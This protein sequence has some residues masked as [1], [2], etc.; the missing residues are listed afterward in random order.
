[1]VRAKAYSNRTDLNTALPKQAAS[2]NTG[3]RQYGDRQ[4]DLQAQEDLPVGAPPGPVAPGPLPGVGG[5]ITP[6]DAPS[7]FPEEPVTAGADLG[8][9]P[10][11]EVLAQDFNAAPPHNLLDRI[12]QQSGD[13]LLQSL[14][15][16][17]Y[18]RMTR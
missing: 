9:G 6:F 11:T 15:R 17:S 4:A 3:N 1:M 8:P 13:P 2:S 16:K 5:N 12:A 18:R 7:N 10:G 14:A